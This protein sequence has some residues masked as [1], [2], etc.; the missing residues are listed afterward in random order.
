MLRGKLRT[1]FE[2]DNMQT[3]RSLKERS[4]NLMVNVDGG[5]LKSS[6][7]L[8]MKSNGWEGIFP[9]RLSLSL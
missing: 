5:I 6:T 3:K 2:D 9:E 1:G 4:F 8:E 7:C